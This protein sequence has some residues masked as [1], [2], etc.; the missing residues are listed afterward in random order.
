M[1]EKILWIVARASSRMFGGKSLARN[2]E[3]LHASLNFATD[4]FMGAQK[5]KTYPGI[6][7]PVLARMLPEVRRIHRHYDVT[8]KAVKSILDA[9][10]DLPKKEN[11]FL[12]WMVDDA[13]GEERELKFLADIL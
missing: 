10:K 5:I 1:S 13:Q 7:R 11:D 3:W 9:R 2:N 4:G 12:Q 6:L 8:R